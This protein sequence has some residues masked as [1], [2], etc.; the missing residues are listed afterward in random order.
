VDD[1]LSLGRI[2]GIRIGLNWSLLLVVALIAWSL[3]SGLLPSEVSG[4][5][6][7][8]YWF[9]GL[10]GAILFMASLLAHE[11]AHSLVA[12]RLG[13]RVEGITLWLFGGVSRLSGDA[14]SARAEVLITVVG[15]LTSLV[16]GGVFFLV[17]LGLSA[18]RTPGLAAATVSWLA[19]INVTL[20]VFNLVPAF[21][22]DGGRV[23]RALIWGRTGDRVRA[24]RIAARVG[25]VFAFLLI[26]LG[27]VDFLLAGNVVGGV[28]M[29]FLGWFLLAAAR[30]EE[31]GLV[32]RQAL[33]RVTVAEVMTP[34]PI[35]APDYITVQDLIDRFLFAHRHTTFP[36][37]DLEGHLTGLVT[38]PG[39]K[40]VRPEAR[41]STRVRDIACPLAEVPVAAPG[42][43]LV[44][45]L[46]RMGGCGEGR[47]L[48]LWDG[49]LVGIVSPTDVSR[50]VQR[51][52][53]REARPAT[54]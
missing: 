4:R 6:V 48:V 7:G 13:V 34:E 24:T 28:W 33:G 26:G 41:A 39:V 45:L 51:S 46:E 16:L 54:R 29:V 20:A 49:R 25:T 22:L 11:L 27:V 36:T 42:D 52:S 23:L 2:A 53:V 18:G 12:Q 17:G 32:L 50:T 14:N 1:S 19:V 15:P 40:G 10:V 44:S 31:S 9:A 38:L 21:P 5:S 35:Q 3:A 37:H 47:A 8:W 43:S 30:S